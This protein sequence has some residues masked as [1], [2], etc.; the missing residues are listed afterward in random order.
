MRIG[1]CGSMISPKTDPVGIDI[2]DDLVRL[3][4]DYIE[5]S[6]ADVAALSEDQFATLRQR[7]EKSGIACEACNNFF[8]PTMRLTGPQAKLA[9]SLDY[10]SRA[11][12]R[13]A[14]LGAKIVVFGSAVAKNVPPGFPHDEAMKQ[15]AE[16]LAHMGP[17]AQRVGI[18]I[19]IEPINRGESNILH[20]ASQGLALARQIN[21]PNIQLLI[22]YY[23]LKLEAEDPAIILQAGDAI[24]HVHFAKI[25]N[26]VFPTE[27]DPQYAAFFDCL[28]QIGYSAR[29]SI[30]AYSQDFTNDARKALIVLKQLI[31]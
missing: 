2:I 26:R 6:M 29:C 1:C 9:T 18:V 20:L 25:E 7:V 3:G 15:I 21:H 16:L 30:E 13:A 22:D 31:K 28:R 24:R 27:P 11:L 4:F 8:P 23:H 12:D 14:A 17:I 5:L 10:V 19:P